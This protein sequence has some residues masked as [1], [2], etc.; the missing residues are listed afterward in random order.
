MYLLLVTKRLRKQSVGL[1]TTFLHLKLRAYTDVYYGKDAQCPEEWKQW[2]NSTGILPKSLR[3]NG[4][5]DLLK[6]LDTSVRISYTLHVHTLIAAIVQEAVESLMCYL[7]TG[8]TFTPCHKDLCAS[9]GHNI[10]CYTEDDG[11]SFWFMT[12]STDAPKAGEYFQSHIGLELDWEDHVA[13]VEEFAGATFTIYVAE[14]RL[15]D[16]VLVPPRSCHQVVNKGG[17]T[18][19]TSWSRMTIAGLRAALHHELPIYRR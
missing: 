11:S 18:M 1:F 15:G 16:L 12:A 13:T 3:P 2:V 9:S 19:K 4:T 17:L 8:D 7:G 14:Q 6:N 5:N 10:M